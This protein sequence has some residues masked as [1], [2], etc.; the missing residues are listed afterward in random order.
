MPARF[1]PR[2]VISLHPGSYETSEHTFGGIMRLIMEVPALESPMTFSRKIL[3]KKKLVPSGRVEALDEF[4]DLPHLNILLRSVLTH[5]GRRIC[6][7]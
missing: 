3:G 1:D 6:T 2:N 7:F 5:L 4:F